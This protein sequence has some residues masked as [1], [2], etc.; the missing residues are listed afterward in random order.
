MKSS[1]FSLGVKQQI[2]RV[3]LDKLLCRNASRPGRTPTPFKCLLLT[4]R[5]PLHIPCLELCI[6]FNCC[7]GV[8]ALTVDG[9]IFSILTTDG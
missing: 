2:A 9:Y 7:N 4:K 6:S 8:V 5:Y 1:T 3:G